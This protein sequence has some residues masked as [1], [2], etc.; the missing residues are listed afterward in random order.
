MIYDNDF[1][2]Y[3]AINNALE[4]VT[5]SGGWKDIDET[6]GTVISAGPLFP[7]DA[8]DLNDK[9]DFPSSATGVRNS[10]YSGK[11]LPSDPTFQDPYQDTKMTGTE[12][13]NQ[14]FSKEI[15]N[16]LVANV[17]VAMKARMDQM[18]ADYNRMLLAMSEAFKLTT[19]TYGAVSAVE[20]NEMITAVQNAIVSGGTSAR[21]ATTEQLISDNEVIE[22]DGIDYHVQI[23]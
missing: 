1:G 16:Y 15:L 20:Y 2:L 21:D 11:G 17:E 9:Y 19:N 10:D 4:H 23:K 7:F 22:V 12:M 13:T 3:E 14:V 5:I 6:Y 8:D 18:E